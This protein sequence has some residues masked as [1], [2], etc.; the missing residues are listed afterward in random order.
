MLVYTCKSDDESAVGPENMAMSVTCFPGAC[1]TFA[2]VF[3]C[4]EETIH[5][6][7]RSLKTCKKWGLAI[8]HPLILP[9]IFAEQERK[10]LIDRLAI[11][12]DQLYQHILD[13]KLQLREENDDI[14]ADDFHGIRKEIDSHPRNQG[15]FIFRRGARPH[16]RSHSGDSDRPAS[17]SVKECE[18]VELWIQVSK[19]KDGLESFREQLKGML[20]HT[21]SLSKKSCL[22]PIGSKTCN[23]TPMGAATADTGKK[24]EARL[25][26]MVS[27]L[28]CKIRS[29]EG[30]LEGMAMARQVVSA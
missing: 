1:L 26:R 12:H 2:M 21:R 10:R 9:M 29:S 5:D 17:S 4:T 27:E 8:H 24:A 18:A 25:E 30:I 6:I 3:S 16:C 13:L 7:T 15:W 23:V 11:R 19:L 14:L 28:D 20:E 22:L